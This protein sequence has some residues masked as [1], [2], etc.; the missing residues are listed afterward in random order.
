[1]VVAGDSK[2][3]IKKPWTQIRAD[4]F[5]KKQDNVIDVSA[6]IIAVIGFYPCQRFVL[7]SWQEVHYDSE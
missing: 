4:L 5:M 7:W 6:L 1:M 3:R 2:S